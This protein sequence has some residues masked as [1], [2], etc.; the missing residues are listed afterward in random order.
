VESSLRDFGTL[1]QG[2]DASDMFSTNES[3]EDLATRHMP[4]LLVEYVAAEME[5]RIRTTDREERMK[6]LGSSQVRC[7]T[8]SSNEIMTSNVCY[9]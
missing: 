8:A 9:E 1:S 6:R 4:Y 7:S 5:G 3:L 2:I